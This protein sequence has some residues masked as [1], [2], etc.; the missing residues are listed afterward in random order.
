MD[1]RYLYGMPDERENEGDAEEFET[2][3][4]FFP[5]GDEEA[6]ALREEDLGDPVEVQVEGVFSAES[7]GFIQRFVL[8]TDGEPKLPILIGGPEATSISYSLEGTQ[9]DRPM[10]H[11]LM[12][13]IIERLNGT[14]LRIILDDIWN[15]TYYAKLYIQSGEEELEIDSRPSDA[16]GLALRFNAPIYVLDGIMDQGPD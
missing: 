13:V 15:K 9:P 12:K 1:R 6:P 11:D 3:P 2:P 5:Y 14:L 10:T 7:N 4:P 8:L 16:I